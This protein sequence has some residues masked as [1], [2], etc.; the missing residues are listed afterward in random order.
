ML[1]SLHASA[2]IA[3]F[4]PPG[5]KS[6][7]VGKVSTAHINVGAL[8]ALEANLKAV[9][10]SPT[11]VDLD[12]GP[13]L[14]SAKPAA[15]IKTEYRLDGASHKK[16][17]LPL[18]NNKLRSIPA[19]PEARRILQ[20]YM[21]LIK[22][23]EAQVATVFVADEP[24]L[25]GIPKSELERIAKTMRALFAEHK[26][27]NVKLGVIFA[28]GMVNA[29]FAKLLDSEAGR[30]VHNIDTYRQQ[31]LQK[32]QTQSATADELQWLKNIAQNRLT[33]YDNAGNL[34]VEGGLPKGFDLYGYDF[35][36][37][38]VLQDALYENMLPALRKHVS[39]GECKL[40]DIHKMSQLRSQLSFYQDGP[41]VKPAAG[42]APGA[43]T[44]RDKDRQLLDQLFQCRMTAA[45]SML[46][47]EITKIGSKAKILLITESS[48]NGVMEF[49][50]RQNIES[51]QPPLLI[52][53]RVLD[54]V[55]RAI[56][57]YAQ[58]KRKGDIA[59]LEFFTF[60][61]TFDNTIQLNV[62]GFAEMP[63]V[64]SLIFDTS[65][66]M[67]CDKGSLAAAACR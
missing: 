33:T 52:E 56:A 26:I 19:D 30:Y 22:R 54:E 32:A 21:A 18:A 5:I 28:S 53:S 59:A 2:E 61:N 63:A 55:K 9:V 41:I 62:G 10:G 57:F 7:F 11:K 12:F 14:N 13:V 44:P 60:E 37:S 58:E 40:G 42:S 4:A 45:T 46:R 66:R 48:N 16:A 49:D 17:L 23:Y 36:L 43:D 25:N 1:L 27:R 39:Q 15:Q 51:G 35:Y 64:K 65:K 50:A 31:L 47:K 67:M 8:D 34:Y 6:E 24:Y 38:T 29:E 3:V 20:P